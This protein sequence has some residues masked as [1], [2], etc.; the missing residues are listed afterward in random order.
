MK[1]K[2]LNLAI[3]QAGWIVCV[4]GG[5]LYAIVYTAIALLIHHWYVLEKNSEW[6]LI[7]IVTVVGS[8]WDILMALS[9]MLYYADSGFLGIPIWLICLWALFATTFMHSLSWFSRYLW[10]AAIFAAVMG[11]ASYWFGSELSDAYFGTPILISLV[12]MAVGWS[13]LFP[14][15][16]YLTRR[17]QQ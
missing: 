13:I 8:L 10:I 11:P 5:D 15:G 17:Y 4:V 2:I 12:V 3:F 7:A 6:Q 1:T 14:A 9:G 16:I